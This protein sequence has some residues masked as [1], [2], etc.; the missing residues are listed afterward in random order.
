TLALQHKEIPPHLHLTEPNPHISWHA[1]E[2]PTALTPWY[3]LDKS[4]L[5]KGESRI[6]GVSSFGWSG[7]NA[8]VILEEAPPVKAIGTS[9]THQ[10][11]LLSAKTEA[12][13]DMATDN[14]AAY[15]KQHPQ[16]DLADVAYTHQ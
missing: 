9:R 11:L 6:A 2:I 13:L 16:A 8:H 5:Y 1:V 15:L 14:L 10:V 7:T 4:A 12:A 3:V